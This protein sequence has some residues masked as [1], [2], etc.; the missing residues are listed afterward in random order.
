MSRMTVLKRIN[1]SMTSPFEVIEFRV[2]RIPRPQKCPVNAR[3]MRDTNTWC[4][5]SLVAKA[6]H[7]DLIEIVVPVSGVTSRVESASLARNAIHMFDYPHRCRQQIGGR[8]PSSPGG[9][10]GCRGRNVSGWCM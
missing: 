3:L 4:R 7:L 6:H 10:H 1:R 9:P 2:S 8:R 5:T